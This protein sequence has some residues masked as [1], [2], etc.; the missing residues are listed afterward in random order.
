[1]RWFQFGAFCPLF[2][3]HGHRQP[4]DP[5]SSCGGSGGKNEIWEF[6]NVAY[7]AITKVIYLREQLRGYVMDQMK[8][9]ASVG[10][11]VLRPL[12]FDFPLDQA[13]YGVED[14]YMFGPDWLVA[15]VLQYRATNRNVYLPTLPPNQV[16]THFFTNQD[17]N[18]GTVTIATPIDTFPLF[19]RKRIPKVAYVAAVQLYSAQ[20][21]DSVL[22]LS[23][24][25]LS[26]NCGSACDGNYVLVRTEGYAVTQQD[27]SP[28]LIPLQLYYSS[29]YSDN[30]VSAKTSPP[31]DSYSVNFEDG[32]VWQNCTSEMVPLDLFFN[33]N[34]NHHITVA[35]LEGHAWAKAN[36][37]VFVSNQGC[38]LRSHP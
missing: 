7:P 15:P 24:E 31:D 29:K 4:E 3:L 12:F 22:C 17:Y 21:N 38:I 27:A 34:T 5:G 32:F 36:N 37:F 28:N 6:G 18:P 33:K 8:L 11:P 10:T 2:R 20:R 23:Q 1:V 14:Q 13:A 35:S 19:F 30:F 16:W 9:A 25:C 26:S